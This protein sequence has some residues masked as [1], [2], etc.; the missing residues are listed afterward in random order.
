MKMN[1]NELDKAY[2]QNGMVYGDVKDLT[3][4]VTFDKIMCD[5]AFNIAKSLKYNGY[6]CE[7]ASMVY[8]CFEKKISDSGIKNENISNKDFANES[9]R[10]VI[11]KFEKRK[12]HSTFINNIWGVDLADIQLTSN[13]WKEFV[14]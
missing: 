9:H 6:P 12:V 3:R 10:A 13:V 4:R 5:Q 7:L 11:K 14:F 2:F 8:K 1:Q